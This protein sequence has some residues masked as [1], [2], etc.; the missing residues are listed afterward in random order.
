VDFIVR[1]AIE[2]DV[3]A[4]IRLWREMMDFHANLEPRFRPLPPPEGEEAWEKHM[5]EDVWGNEEWCIFVAE[6]EGEVIGQ[7]IG[8][9]RDEYPVFEPLQYGYVTDV[10]VDPVARR[11]GVGRALFEAVKGW[12]RTHGISHLRLMV[13]HNNPISQP[14]WRALGCTDYMDVMWYDLEAEGE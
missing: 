11:S 9:L 6:S 2:Q 4:M 14:F 8:T 5:R 12:F 1:P 10:A 13:A 3:P 7:M